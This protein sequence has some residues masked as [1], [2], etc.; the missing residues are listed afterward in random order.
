[1]LQERHHHPAGSGVGPGLAWKGLARRLVLALFLL[2]CLGGLA[3]AEPPPASETLA[4]LRTQARFFMLDQDHPRALAALDK[5]LELE[6]RNQELILLKVRALQASGGH[7]R[8]MQYM[9]GLWAQDAEGFAYLRFEAGF[10]RVREHQFDKALI[11]F[12]KAETADRPR[13]VREQALT[14]L[15]MRNYDQAL[16]ALGRLDQQ[17]AATLYLQGQGLYFKKDY[18]AARQALQKALSANPTAQEARDIQGMLQAV[19][20]SQRAERPWR[21]HA[22]VMTQYEDNVFRDPLQS[23]PGAQ[24]PRGRG[25]WSFMFKQDLEYRLGQRDKLSWGLLG[26][27]Q[28][29]SYAQLHEADYAALGLGAYLDLQGQGWGLR[30]PYGYSYYWAQA[31]HNRKVQVNGISPTLGWQHSPTLRSEVSGLLQH[32]GYLQTGQPDVW[33]WRLGLTHF[34]SKDP[35]LLPHLR[36]GYAVDQDTASDEV[37]GYLSWELS[38]GGALPLTKQLSL[39]ASLTYVRY[40][41]D[42]R[43]DP[44]N[45]GQAPGQTDRKDDQYLAGLRLSYR[46]RADWRVVL[47]YMHDLNNSNINTSDGFEP[48]DFRRN[49]VSLMVVWSF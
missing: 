24:P 42:R 49:I 48:Y 12:K 16:A 25:D 4:I 31:T 44:Y 17:S 18:P 40:T 37:S 36:L 1:M 11:H 9:R 27:A 46:P 29:V 35:T 19:A 41:F 10:I 21:A 15:K 6:P 39:D 26:Q 2:G 20:A 23:Y 8:A 22:T 14:Y 33:R 38:L 47:G 45:L 13:A 5:A 32:R 30:M 34:L 3:A 7:E 28:Y 43:V